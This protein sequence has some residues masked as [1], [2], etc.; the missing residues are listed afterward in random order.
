M[1]QLRFEKD[2]HW[3]DLSG[4]RRVLRQPHPGIQRKNMPEL[5][6]A[7]CRRTIQP[8]HPS[9][10]LHHDRLPGRACVSFKARVKSQVNNGLTVYVEEETTNWQYPQISGT[11]L[12]GTASS[13]NEITGTVIP[14]DPG[15]TVFV[16][17]EARGC[18]KLCKLDR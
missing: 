10:L 7:G 4:N 12:S 1:P 5:L 13:W 11:M 2:T 6:R 14:T 8:R 17:F 15:G 16:F 18:A 3:L 9:L